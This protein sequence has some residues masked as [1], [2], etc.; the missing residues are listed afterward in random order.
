MW[1]YAAGKHCL[2]DGVAECYAQRRAIQPSVLSGGQPDGAGLE[3]AVGR[4]I[5]ANQASE[6]PEI[7]SED[8]PTTC[9]LPVALQSAVLSI[10]QEVTLNAWRRGERRRTLLGLAQDSGYFRVQ[11]QD[12]GGG[13]DFENDPRDKR[14]LKRIQDLVGRLGGAVDTCSQCG[15]GTCVVVELPLVREDVANS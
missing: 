9:E 14:R 7:K 15:N 5:V 3:A 11:V 1:N 2:E 12:R 10:V 4:L 13:S 6:G 8:A